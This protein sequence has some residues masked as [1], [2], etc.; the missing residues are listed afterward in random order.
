MTKKFG[1]NFNN[2]KFYVVNRK[3]H[4]HVLYLFLN[5]SVAFMVYN[6]YKGSALLPSCYK[7]YRGI[8]S[9]EQQ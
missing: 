9:K 8:F 4:L 3:M 2:V 7:N 1:P 5:P 6:T